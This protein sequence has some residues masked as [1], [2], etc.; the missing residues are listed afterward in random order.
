MLPRNMLHTVFIYNLSAATTVRG[1]FLVPL[2]VSKLSVTCPTCT[3]YISG[4]YFLLPPLPLNLNGSTIAPF[5]ARIVL[6]SRPKLITAPW[7]SFARETV[8]IMPTRKISGHRETGMVDIVS[9]RCRDPSCMRRPL[10]NFDGQRPVCCSQH[11]LPGMIDVVS[12]RCQEP[13]R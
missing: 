8:K 12:T 13:V 10:Y 11:K 4:I 5:R 7:L 6:T 2:Y 1:D 9:R 3:S